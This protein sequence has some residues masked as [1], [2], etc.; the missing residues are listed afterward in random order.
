MLA[1]TAAFQ[2]GFIF[3]IKRMRSSFK[4]LAG[5]LVDDVWMV[6]CT[7]T[8]AHFRGQK[9]GLFHGSRSVRSMPCHAAPF[10]LQYF[11]SFD[12][13]GFDFSNCCAWY[14]HLCERLGKTAFDVGTKEHCKRHTFCDCSR[15]AFSHATDFAL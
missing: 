14:E 3:K 6:G 7:S 8:W 5:W 4:F 1:E 2:F 10:N 15:N 11:V 12:E 13:P 9:F